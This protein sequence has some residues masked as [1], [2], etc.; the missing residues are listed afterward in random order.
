VSISNAVFEEIT[1]EDLSS[2]IEAG[3]AEGRLLEY[4]SAPYG[5]TDDQVREFLKDASSFANTY[6][7]HLIIG[8]E[9]V[10]GIATRISPLAGIDLD[11][12]IARLE[13]LLRD[14]LQ[15]RVTGIRIR[16]VPVVPNGSVIVIRVPR[17]WNPPHRVSVRNW[18]RI[19]ARN[20]AGAHEMSMDEL[21]ASF[22]L[23][24]SAY[25]RARAFR[26]ERL[27][28]ID[29]LETP[30]AIVDQPR[31]RLVL[32]LLPLSAFAEPGTAVDLTSDEQRR[33]LDPTLWPIG[34]RADQQGDATRRINYEGYVT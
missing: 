4:K 31:D 22:T 25:D 24:A 11:Q 6:G 12:E 19:F 30:V 28:L 16:A 32:H 3:A 27:A 15:P 26:S 20:S 23:G 2:L 33:H 9:E 18:N 7:S 5:R 29:A 34:W 17:S 14:G 1:E 21:R 8:M 10:Q 13:N